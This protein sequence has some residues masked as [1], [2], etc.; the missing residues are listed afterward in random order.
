M[1]NRNVIAGLLAGCVMVTASGAW[2]QDW[3]QWRGP[4]RDGKA[5]GFNAPNT[6]PKELAQKWK[7]KVGD[8]VATPALVG[9]KLYVFARV[10]GDEIIRALDAASGNELWQDK[11][12]AQPA[13]GAAASFPGPRSSPT[14][15]E[16]KVVTLGVQSTLSCLD[17]ASGKLLWRKNDVKGN[18]RFFTSSS[19]II[20]DGLC[21]AE[22]GG[23]SSGAMVAYDLATGEEKWK[24]TGDGTA[25]AS[26]ML[27]TVDGIKAVVAETAGHIVAISLADGKPLWQKPFKVRYN[28]CTPI[29][30]GQTII[31]SGMGQGTTA[32]KVEKQGDKLVAKDL[33]SNPD[34]AVQFNTPVVKNG[35]VFG[36]SEDDRLFCINEETGK[37][38]WSNPKGPA[39]GARQA[40]GG[41]PGG[42]GGGGQPGG[43][44]RGGRGRGG[45]GRGGMGYRPGYGSIVDA[46]PV[47]LALTPKSEL[48]VLE[49]TDKEFKQVARYKVATSPTYAYPVVSG[50][51]IFIKD[52]DSV[53]LWTVD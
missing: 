42:K 25:Y 27:L 40:G 10:E 39:A 51:R 29:I 9:D 45:M 28:A 18:P 6:W 7:A 15:A 30:D 33:W 53:T 13:R 34:N 43:K 22:L 46:G 32:V 36:I 1:K 14:V 24:W 16:G 38:A 35:L 5:T 21:V 4:N 3:P 23:E 49:P 48:L 52:Q 41:Q 37:T 20:V 31:Y 11:Y 8:G 17:A 26:P 12:E 50:N 44:G 19:P 2:G 47:L